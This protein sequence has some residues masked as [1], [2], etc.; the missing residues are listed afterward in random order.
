[1]I[2]TEKALI[3]VFKNISITLHTIGT[4]LAS[5]FFKK[6]SIIKANYYYKKVEENIKKWLLEINYM[7]KTNNIVAKRR[8]I[9]IVTYFRNVAAD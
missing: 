1:M 8:V 7:I 6:Y 5:G 4:K 2:V 9:V 3:A